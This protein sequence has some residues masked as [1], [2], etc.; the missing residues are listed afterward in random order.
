MQIES[1]QQ[2]WWAGGK[3]DDSEKGWDEEREGN[4]HLPHVSSPPSFQ[5]WLRL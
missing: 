1:V 4:L 5:P 2:Q 3:Y